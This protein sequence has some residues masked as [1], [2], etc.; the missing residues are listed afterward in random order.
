MHLPWSLSN[1]KLY[2]TNCQIKLMFLEKY[3]TRCTLLSWLFIKLWPTKHPV[4]YRYWLISSGKK[5]RDLVLSCLRQFITVWSIK[6]MF[7]WDC[8]AWFVV[9]NLLEINLL[10]SCFDTNSSATAVKSKLSVIYL[11]QCRI[12]RLLKR[13]WNIVDLN[14]VLI[15]RA[16]EKRFFWC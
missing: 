3:T 11:W 14:H 13:I 9:E 10:V 7:G 12:V 2:C 5:E 15:R 4:F 1:A 8:L 16:I 6:S